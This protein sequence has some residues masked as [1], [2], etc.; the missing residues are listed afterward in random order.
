M[1][2][3]AKELILEYTR[4]RFSLGVTYFLEHKKSGEFLNFHCLPQA[5]SSGKMQRSD[6]VTVS[7]KGLRRQAF[8]GRGAQPS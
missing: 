2:K 7:T 5:P 1:R 6:H 4:V 3:D 8:E